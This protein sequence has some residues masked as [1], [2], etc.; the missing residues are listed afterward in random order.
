M[1]WQEQLSSL[2]G[3]EVDAW[4]QAAAAAPSDLEWIRYRFS[5]GWLN[6]TA[7]E[8]ERWRACWVQLGKFVNAM[9]KMRVA[10]LPESDSG[11]ALDQE[12][13]RARQAHQ[14][15]KVFQAFEPEYLITAIE[16]CECLCEDL[17]DQLTQLMEIRPRHLHR[18]KQLQK[19]VESWRAREWITG[20]QQLTDLTTP[21]AKEPLRSH[22][23][24][25]WLVVDVVWLRQYQQEQD[26]QQNQLQA[27]KQA[28]AALEHE[29]NISATQSIVALDILE[30]LQSITARFDPPGHACAEQN[31]SQHGETLS[32]HLALL[33]NT[34]QTPAVT[35]TL[36][37]F[38]RLRQLVDGQ[39]WCQTAGKL[40]DHVSQHVQQTAQAFRLRRFNAV[41]Q[42][43]RSKL[44]EILAQPVSAW[45]DLSQEIARFELLRDQH[46]AEQQRWQQTWRN[47]PA[48]LR[49]AVLERTAQIGDWDEITR[50]FVEAETEIAE[51]FRQRLRELLL[52]CEELRRLL[53]QPLATVADI[54]QPGSEQARS[55][56]YAAEWSAYSR[57]TA[58]HAEANLIARQLQACRAQAQAQFDEELSKLLIGD[59]LCQF[60]LQVKRYLDAHELHSLQQLLRLADLL[61]HRREW[62]EFSAEASRYPRLSQLLRWQGVRARL[63]DELRPVADLVWKFELC[64]RQLAA[65]CDDEQLAQA[66]A[67]VREIKTNL[68]SHA[69]HSPLMDPIWRQ[70]MDHSVHLLMDVHYHFK[71]Q[72]IDP[73]RMPPH[74]R[75]WQ[76]LSPAL[77]TI[78]LQSKLDPDTRHAWYHVT[79][80]T[81]DKE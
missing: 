64:T 61:K 33:S 62:L 7:V 52:Q 13:A 5:C 47:T 60:K 41:A 11:S 40:R 24:Q 55:E 57:L 49:A 78:D 28:A 63:P 79:Q 69:P 48:E 44:D 65:P 46:Q 9:E 77:Q 10:L 73:D 68:Q 35:E 30:E 56:Y 45:R 81:M 51:H 20:A 27:S 43:L 66:E 71:R 76:E 17:C 4:L 32:H 8:D 67:L 53:K 74:V 26:M 37:R 80:Q 6:C 12:L 2:R 23:A 39:V 75:D 25:H 72:K 1:D 31:I 54:V 36:A 15:H 58:I 14:T 3:E 38:E 59:E 42:L 22:N 29:L 34:E 70:L 50:I 16:R 18:W 19:V 21:L